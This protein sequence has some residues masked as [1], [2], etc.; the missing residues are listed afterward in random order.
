MLEQKDGT[1]Y[2]VGYSKADAITNKI[3]PAA[4]SMG[5]IVKSVGTLYGFFRSPD[6]KPH[7][8]FIDDLKPVVEHDGFF[9]K[10][11]KHR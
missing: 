11:E 3:V 6:K 2:Y 1:C 4:K 7:Q 8:S 10:L 5:L 9:Y